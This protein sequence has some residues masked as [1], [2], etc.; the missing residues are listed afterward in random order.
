MESEIK[1][2]GVQD[3]YYT[4]DMKKM[5]SKDTTY[6]LKKNLKENLPSYPS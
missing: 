2:R 3:C 1:M 6:N 4:M 5:C